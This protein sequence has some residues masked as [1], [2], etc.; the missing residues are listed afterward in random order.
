MWVRSVTS[1]SVLN[2]EEVRKLLKDS[3]SLLEGHFFLSSGLHSSQY[4]QCAKLLE[5]PR[6]AELIGISIAEKFSGQILDLIGGPALG[7]VILGHE[8]ARA[9]GA[10]FLFAERDSDGKM[11]FRRGFKVVPGERGIV[12]EDVLTTGGSTREVVDLL[13]AAGAEL[14]GV[15]AIVDRSGGR[16][17]FDLPLVTLLQLDIP[18]W[19]PQD[20]PLCKR[21]VPVEKPGSRKQ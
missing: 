8:V 7:A 12:V 4:L 19:T 15:A 18:A 2:P 21:G 20:C 5:D 14:R 17:Q 13:R 16:V 3:G 11:A 6:R 10:R 1:L 9:A